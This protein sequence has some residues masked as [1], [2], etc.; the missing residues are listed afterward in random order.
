[1]AYF[2]IV[3]GK[4]H[5]K[6]SVQ[7]VIRYIL[8]KEKCPHKVFHAFGNTCEDIEEIIYKFLAVQKFYR[9]EKGK[10]IIHLILSFSENESYSFSTYLDIGYKI[11]DYFEKE[12]QCIFALHEYDNDGKPTLPHI[13]VAVNPI[14]YVNGK[15]MK[16]DKKELFALRKYMDMIV[17]N[18]ISST[19]LKP[20]S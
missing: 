5:G 9:N 19:F 10:R 12:Y 6:R 18:G 1:M 17:P 2:K 11:I 13:H 14:N 7:N 20:P 4:Y 8:N 16:L 3:P 15:R